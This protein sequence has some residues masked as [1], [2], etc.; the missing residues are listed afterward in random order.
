M[1]RGGRVPKCQGTFQLLPADPSQLFNVWR[2][3]EP[4]MDSPAS[5]HPARHEQLPYMA[6]NLLV[7][8]LKLD[9]S[10]IEEDMQER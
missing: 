4:L 5:T 9:K 3:R 1:N 10:R 7:I 6:A 2:P 8:P